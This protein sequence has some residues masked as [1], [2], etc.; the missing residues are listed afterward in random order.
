MSI[1][2]FKPALLSMAIAS[3]ISANVFADDVAK[4]ASVG[5]QF[6]IFGSD[7]SVNNIP[8]SAHQLTQDDL[9]KFD[10]SD[11]MRS[12]TSIPGV[13]VLEE[14]GYGLRANI[15]MRGTG[16]N[17]SEKVTIMEDGVLAAPAPYAAP[18]AYYFPTAGR[19]QQVE[20]LKGTS[21]AMYGP[22]TTGGVVNMLSRQIPEEALAGQIK[23]QAGQDGFAKLH[24][25]I[26]GQ[27][28][29]VSSLFEVFRYQ[30][31]GF[32]NI[33]HSNQDTGFVKNDI[34]GKVRFNTDGDATFDQELEFKVKYS[35]E[36][37]DDTYMGLTQADFESDPYSRYSA[38]QKD[39]MAT[40]HLQLQLS[41]AIELS[42]RFNLGTTVYHN[43]F[44]R[45]WYKTSKIGQ[46]EEDDEGNSSIVYQ[47]LSKGT[48]LASDYDN[49]MIDELYTQVKANNRDYLSQG[50]QTVLDA[51]LNNH[52][53]KLGIRYHQD[54]MDRYQWVD[55]YYLD[56]GYNMTLTSEGT[57][58]TDSNRI[59]SASALALFIHDEWTIGKFVVN[60]GLRYEDMTLEREDWDT[61][62]RSLPAK[63][64]KN[65]VEVV[66]PSLAM[67]YHLTDDL[68]LLG[69]VQKGFAPPSPGNEEATNE[70]SLNYELGARYGKNAFNAE[71][72]VFLSDYDNMHGNCTASQNCDDDNIGEQYNTGEVK[73]TGI[74][75]KTGYL[76][77]FN[78]I[79]MPIDLTYT[80]T[81]TEFSNSF[82]SDFWGV[83]QAGDEF[84]YVPENQFQLTLGL[85]GDKWR[86]NVL[87]R[88]TGEMRSKA[89]VGASE[90]NVNAHTVVDFVA[91]YDIAKNQQ[92]RFS[93]DNLLDETYMATRMH[94]SVMVGKPQTLSL[95]YQYNF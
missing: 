81:Q 26:G 91:S 33:N 20:V 15:G 55:K 27:G 39:N 67:T 77:D 34:L 7:T 79:S 12:L 30:A 6:T 38:S 66:L 53:L 89:G 85:A 90:D 28:E 13:Y 60:A 42:E 45:N 14:D 75:L 61:E 8:G 62:D 69:G 24:G 43:D 52:Q 32:K 48:Q 5:E 86:T 4:E 22:R 16:Q 83:V 80:H 70:E 29:N 92:V 25:F 54:E 84:P 64:S 21:S 72:L 41:H 56:A 36:D 95:G 73:I 57:P 10:Y 35:D 63:T 94:G 49:G 68:V 40:E 50:I 17:R 1:K 71:A 18:S 65:T 78:E 59:D 11:I 2:S 46:L 23:V 37:S 93:V 82:K 58:G 3:T 44:S 31:D 87:V 76:F 19:M 9:E 74:E 47:S 51:D 88:Y